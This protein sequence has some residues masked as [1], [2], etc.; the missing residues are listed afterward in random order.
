MV[1]RELEYIQAEKFMNDILLFK[2]LHKF[3]DSGIFGSTKKRIQGM[4][5]LIG[6]Q[7]QGLNT[8]PTNTSVATNE[9]RGAK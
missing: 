9:G 1:Q 5:E 6:Q 8:S 7:S 4:H 3:I 2:P